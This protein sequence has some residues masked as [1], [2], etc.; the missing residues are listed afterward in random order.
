MSAE[1]E[2]CA[3]KTVGLLYTKRNGSLG[4]RPWD[5]LQYVVVFHVKSMG[6]EETWR[7]Q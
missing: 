4:T 6:T 7:L 1:V 2:K 3:F 5:T